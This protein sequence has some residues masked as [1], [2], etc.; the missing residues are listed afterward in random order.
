MGRPLGP[1]SLARLVGVHPHLVAIIVRGAALS[2]VDVVVIEGLRTTARQVQLYAQGR[3][4]PGKIITWTMASKH[5]A[6]PDGFGHAT[7]AGPLKD[8]RIDWE[9]LAGFDAIAK[10]MAQAAAELGFPLRW[11]ADWDRDGKPRERGE[12]DSPHFELA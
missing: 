9:D 3:T 4:A 11:G 6:Q 2:P 1:T 12:F 7:D 10:A 5:L 8:G